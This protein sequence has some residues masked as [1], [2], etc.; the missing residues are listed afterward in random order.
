MTCPAPSVLIFT[1]LD[2][3]LLDD[4][5]AMDAASA[6]MD[7][8]NEFGGICIPVTS[9][10]FDEV[11]GLNLSRTFPAPVIF[12]NGAGIL[13]PSRTQPEILGMPAATISE[14]LGQMRVKHGFQ[15]RGFMDM[16]AAEV[17]S[18]TGLALAD[19]DLAQ[20]RLASQPLRWNDSRDAL[21]DFIAALEP[22]GL[23]A[24]EGGRFH[25]VTDVQCNKGSAMLR[26]AAGYSHGDATV[27]II[28]CG[29]APNDISML[30]AADFPIV[31]PSRHGGYMQLPGGKDSYRATA[32]GHEAWLVAVSDVI[33]QQFAYNSTLTLHP[34]ECDKNTC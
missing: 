19:A 7:A 3:T 16:D 18:L 9:K 15:F 17:A 13:W 34:S 10:T 14:L 26:A 20:R 8:C 28:A 27:P 2:G 1:D 5:Y 11:K 23:Q 25:C 32:A 21:D 24:V 6:A 33:N 30:V 12:E 29:D 31:F 22:E 4:R